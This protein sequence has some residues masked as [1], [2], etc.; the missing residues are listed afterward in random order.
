[1][2]EGETLFVHS[3]YP[4]LVGNLFARA[5]GL[6]ATDQGHQVCRTSEVTIRGKEYTDKTARC[7]VLGYQDD[8]PKFGI[9]EDVV[10]LQDENLFIVQ[11]MDIEYFDSHIL[12][13]VLKYRKKG[14]CSLLPA[15]FQVAPEVQI[16]TKA[17]RCVV[18]KHIQTE[19]RPLS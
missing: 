5:K 17:K 7:L 3:A 13:H 6:N 11:C 18:F 10:I 14:N 15:V 16:L 2:K 12:T 8:L 19:T 1:M 4:D 9:L